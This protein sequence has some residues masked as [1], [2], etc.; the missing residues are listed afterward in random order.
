MEKYVRDQCAGGKS[1]DIPGDG[2]ITRNGGRS[3][4]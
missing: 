3:G 1:L 2:R 4:E